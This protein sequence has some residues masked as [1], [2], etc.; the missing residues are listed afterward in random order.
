MHVLPS[1]Y[2]FMC[3][4]NVISFISYANVYQ[5]NNLLMHLLMYSNFVESIDM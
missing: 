1:T 2:V 3:H 4:D 5:E